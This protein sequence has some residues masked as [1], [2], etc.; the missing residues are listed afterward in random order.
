MKAISLWQPW[1]SLIAI[2]AKQIETRH[3]AIGYRG[4]L[5]IHAAK[6]RTD[7]DQVEAMQHDAIRYALAR[8]QHATRADFSKLPFGAFVAVARMVGC[9]RISGDEYK[10]DLANQQLPRQLLDRYERRLLETAEPSFGHYADGRYAWLLADV[11]PLP[12][13]IPATGQ[14]RLWSL[15]AAQILAI[16]AQLPGLTAMSPRPETSC[17]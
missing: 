4:L 10:I 12:T 1:A 8:H 2:G 16:S 9:A 11:Q 3:W 15:D 7:A 6:I 5:V 17:A 14:R 13:P